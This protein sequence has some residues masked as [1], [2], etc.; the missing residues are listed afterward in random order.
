MFVGCTKEN[1]KDH[2]PTVSFRVST[3]DTQMKKYIE[4]EEAIKIV[5]VQCDSCSKSYGCKNCKGLN[6]PATAMQL[7][8]SQLIRK[9]YEGGS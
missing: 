8:E 7:E 5:D 6:A 2:E 4:S 9:S 3:Y 1:G